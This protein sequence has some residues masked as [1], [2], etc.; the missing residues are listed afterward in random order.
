MLRCAR[1]GQGSGRARYNEGA[2]NEHH[3]HLLDLESCKLIEFTST[4]I[5][6]LR[7]EIARRLGYRLVGHCPELHTVPLTD[8]RN[9]GGKTPAK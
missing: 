1:R 3:D 5:E 7:D 8:G 4:Q 2:P 9:A 6:R